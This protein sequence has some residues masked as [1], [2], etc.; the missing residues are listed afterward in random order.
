MLLL[1]PQATESDKNYLQTA[2]T[3]S[4]FPLKGPS[5]LKVPGKACCASI[6]Q[7]LP[8]G[9]PV[10]TPTQRE[11][12]ESPGTCGEQA[13]ETG[14]R[15]TLR[16]LLFL[17]HQAHSG[18]VHSTQQILYFSEYKNGHR[19]GKPMSPHCT[20]NHLHHMTHTNHMTRT[21]QMVPL[22]T[23]QSVHSPPGLHQSQPLQSYDPTSNRSP[24]I[25]EPLTNHVSSRIRRSHESHSA[26]HIH[27]NQKALL[28]MWPY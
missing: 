18:N 6:L 3:K 19:K 13:L 26:P 2:V 8:R 9:R 22:I 10:S 1:S 5:N 4:P 23:P 20:I 12:T 16:F 25:T 15:A 17:I 27:T 11:E 7:S 28:I 14:P 24:L 21:H